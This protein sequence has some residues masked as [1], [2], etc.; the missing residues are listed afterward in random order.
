MSCQSP[1]LDCGWPIG[2]CPRLP[3]AVDVAALAKGVDGAR[4]HCPMGWLTILGPVEK[5]ASQAVAFGRHAAAAF[6]SDAHFA[7]MPTFPP[8]R[9]GT[10]DVVRPVVGIGTRRKTGYLTGYQTKRSETYCSNINEIGATC[11]S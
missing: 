10:C 3:A 4:Q 6:P 9:F 11:F 5:E 1:L 7:K 8:L 2:I